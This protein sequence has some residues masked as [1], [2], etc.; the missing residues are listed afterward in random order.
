[1]DENLE[2]HIK[3]SVKGNANIGSSFSSFVAD[4]ILFS[5]KLKSPYF[6]KKNESWKMYVLICLLLKELEEHHTGNAKVVGSSPVEALFFFRLIL[7]L[8]HNCNDHIFQMD[9]M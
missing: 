7:Q 1:M 8:R 4:C 2:F 9:V 3:V 5:C 6:I